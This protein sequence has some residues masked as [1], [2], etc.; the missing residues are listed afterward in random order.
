MSIKPLILSGKR[1]EG[2]ARLKA[3][4]LRFGYAVDFSGITKYADTVRA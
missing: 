3:G 4:I 1:V 2:V